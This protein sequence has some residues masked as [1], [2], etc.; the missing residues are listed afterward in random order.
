MSCSNDWFRTKEARP[1]QKL[2]KV[3]IITTATNIVT[4]SNL[5]YFDPFNIKKYS[6]N[7]KILFALVDIYSAFP[8]LTV[9]YLQIT[10]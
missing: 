9:Y 4:K 3:S 6:V 8:K 5:K 1:I 7:H 2:N 10:F